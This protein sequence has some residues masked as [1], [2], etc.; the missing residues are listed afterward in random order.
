MKQEKSLLHKLLFPGTLMTI[1]VAFFGIGLLIY[2]FTTGS[3]DSIYASF[4]YPITLYA[5][6]ILVL[7][8]PAMVNECK[9]LISKNKYGN[10]YLNDARLRA[11]I[12]L[13]L[14][15]MIN[16]FFVL[17]YVFTRWKTASAWFGAVA[18]YYAVLGFIRFFLL[19]NVK[20]SKKVENLKMD[21]IQEWKIYRRCG[22]LIFA[23][24]MVMLGMVIQMIWQNKGYHYSGLTIYLS[25]TYTFYSMSMAISNLIKYR[26]FDSPLYMATKMINFAVALMSM[27]TLQTAMISQF[28]SGDKTL[29]RVMNTSTGLSVLFFVFL[30]AITMIVHA[31]KKLKKG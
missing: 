31:N 23:L 14:G 25:A 6:M 21:T 20:K 24:N 4:S 3:Q 9:S 15:L 5:V 13:D 17:F 16:I 2:I 19:Y 12:S 11:R 22:Y 30:I 28:G 7:G 29:E 18:G 27:F 10:I 8:I 1:G 26:K